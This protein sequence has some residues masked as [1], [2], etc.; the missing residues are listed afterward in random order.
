[1][2]KF[3]LLLI[4]FIVFSNSYSQEF[5]FLTGTNIT[6]Y[7]FSSEKGGIKTPL[8]SGT[9]F[10]TEMGYMRPLKNKRF[11]HSV[12]VN[13]NDYNVVAGDLAN[14]YKWNTKY[15]GVNNT[16]DFTVPLTTNFKLM[17]N[18]GLN[19]STIIY[20]RQE[21]NGAFYDIMNQD[22]FSGLIF[23]P[24]GSL[25]LKYKLNDFGYL[26]FGYGLSKSV[27]LFNISKEK[28]TTSTNQI[29]FGIHY[30]IIKK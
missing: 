22:E 15:F 14:S 13:L 28:L 12:S 26:S 7:N 2:R 18:A 10:S 17:I 24:N 23:I 27:I 21:I 9:G 4:V 8:F 25:H 5:Y 11:S 3:Y 30:N 19:L 1:M 29:V 6:K 20:G 16:L